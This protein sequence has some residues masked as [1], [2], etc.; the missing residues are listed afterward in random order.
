M[1]ATHNSII[2][3]GNGGSAASKALFTIYYDSGK[4]RYDVEQ[5][6]KPHE[7]MWV[8]VGK[9]IHDQVPDKNG[10]LLP[11]DLTMGSYELQD[12]TDRGVGNLYE[13]KVIVDKTFGHVAYGCAT[14]CGFNT[15]PW[16]YY[17]PIDVG[18]ENATSQDVWDRDNCTSQDISVLDYILHTSWN[19]GNHAIATASKAV[20]TGVA[21]GSTTN[22]ATGTLTIGNINALRCP[23]APVNPSGPANVQN[24]PSGEITEF[25]DTYQI[26]AGQF[27]MTLEPSAYSYDGNSVT[28]SSPVIGSNACWWSGSNM[29]QYP[30]VAGSTWV[31]DQGDAGH[32]QYGLDTVGYGS[33]V[34]N[35]IQTQGAAHDVE[36]PCN[37]YIY[38]SMNYDGID[39]YVTNLLTQTVGS[40]TVRVCR[41][42]VCSGTI[43]Y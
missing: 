18:V 23:Q 20:I 29:E 21:A 42:G 6:L 5:E 22:Y 4:K 9:L 25:E 15:S 39:L 8:D 31:V 13:G 43:P 14:C 17:D 19:T 16:M 26:S 38:Q 28:E 32:N 40:N 34:V 35:L 3:A 2:A 1:D 36:F 30:T 10:L 7:Q 12:L 33:G 37:I 24:V 27:L 11:P 41:A